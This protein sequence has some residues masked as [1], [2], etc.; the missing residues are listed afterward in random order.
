MILVFESFSKTANLKFLITFKHVF[1]MKYLS[2][3]NQHRNRGLNHSL[4]LSYS[5]PFGK[6]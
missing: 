1:Y 4:L 3:Q 5:A 6:V 2:V